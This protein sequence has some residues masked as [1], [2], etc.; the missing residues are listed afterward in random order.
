MAVIDLSEPDDFRSSFG[1][2]PE[3]CYWCGRPLVAA[4]VYWS[5]HGGNLFF[6][7]H[8]GREFALAVLYDAMRG[9]AAII[10][11]R[12]EAGPWPAGATMTE[13]RAWL[14]SGGRV[15]LGGPSGVASL[16]CNP[17]PGSALGR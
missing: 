14:V 3:H 5:G 4:T 7:V 9:E 15:R 8:C 11:Q 16:R 6:H 13:W 17:A 12:V 1:E 10:G 2:T